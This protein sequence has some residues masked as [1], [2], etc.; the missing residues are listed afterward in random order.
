[1]KIKKFILLIGD[2]IILYGSLALALALRYWKFDFSVF[3]SHILPFTPLFIV[4]IVIFFIHDLYSIDIAKNS[5]EFTSALTRSIIVCALVS[6]AYFYLAPF[7]FPVS[8][9]PK[10]NLLLTI[11]VFVVLFC[12]WRYLFNLII[13]SLTPKTNIAIIGYNPQVADL[14]KEIKQK[15]QLGYKLKLIVKEQSSNDLTNEEVNDPKTK[16]GFKNLKQLL[17]QEK[18]NLA[19]IS[20][21]VYK[22]IDVIQA[23]FECLRNKI[24]FINLSVFYEK[25]AKKIPISVINQVWFLENISQ[26]QK[27]AYEF[28]KRI[29]DCI[30]ALIL[31]LFILPFW[32]LIALMIKISSPG[33]IFYKQIRIGKGG[34]PFQLIKFR[35]MIKEAEKDGPKMAQENDPRITKIGRFLRKTRLDELP[36][37]WNIIKGEMSFVGPRAERPEFQETLKSLIPFYQERF[38]IKP[39]LTGWAQIKYGYTSSLDENFE[40]LQYDLYYIKN[41]SFLFD[42]EIILK[43]INIILRGSGR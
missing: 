16:Y 15:P 41:R 5:I 27:K 3:Q 24:D 43:T 31:F 29:F 35:T 26:N 40:K 32:F 39:G 4:W 2:F 18:I 21:E 10:T 1:M 8:I 19:I 13:G 38:L 22:S 7:F 34:K 17:V 23:L 12:A 6:L 28:F 37:L 20:P 25:F 9:A 14:I 42:L 36:Q 33:P 30:L 11:L